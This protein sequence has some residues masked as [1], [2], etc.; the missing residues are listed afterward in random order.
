MLINTLTI[1][2]N[3]CICWTK[4]IKLFLKI[5]FTDYVFGSSRTCRKCFRFVVLVD[6]DLD[7]DIEEN[8]SRI[9]RMDGMDM[10]GT[11]EHFE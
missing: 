1:K 2:I 6:D 4:L 11:F 5:D 7:I 9:D 3:I 10:D 8:D